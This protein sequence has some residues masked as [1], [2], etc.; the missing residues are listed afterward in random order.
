MMKSLTFN[1][2]Y[3]EKLF[4]I[5]LF[6][7][8]PDYLKSEILKRLDFRLQEINE[9]TVILEQGNICC[10]LYILLEGTLEVN[11]ID[12]NGNEVLI[13]HIESPRAFATPHLFKKDNRFPATFRTLEKSVLLTATKDSTFHLIGN[14]NVCTTMRLDVLSRKTIRE[15]ILVYLLKRLKKDT[16]TVKLTHTLTQLAEY[17]NVTRPALSTEF[18]KMEKEGILKR[19]EGNYIELNRKAIKGII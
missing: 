6:S 11:I 3:K 2:C 17:I 10:N 16:S 18:N 9:N 19:K 5:P 8:L 4:S 15:R 14:C 7:E 13:E 1:D 12:A